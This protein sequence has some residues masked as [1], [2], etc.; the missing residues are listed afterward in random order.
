MKST[1][2]SQNL[3]KDPYATFVRTDGVLL[4]V[5]NRKEEYRTWSLVITISHIL[6]LKITVSLRLMIGNL[7]SLFKS[8]LDFPK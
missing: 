8:M 4:E 1:F 6:A 7:S 3:Q 2:P 5:H